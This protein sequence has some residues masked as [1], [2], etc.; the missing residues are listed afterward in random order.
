M[1]TRYKR[2]VRGG[3]TLV[4][5]IVAVV[6]FGMVAAALVVTSSTFWSQADSITSG[7]AR[8]RAMGARSI[9]AMQQEISLATLLARPLQGA[10]AGFLSGAQN[11]RP[12]DSGE[13]VDMTGGED[14]RWF[15]FCVVGAV[16]G[17]DCIAGCVPPSCQNPQPCLWYY[18]GVWPFPLSLFVGG[19]GTCGTIQGGVT[20][21]LLASQI[22]CPTGPAPTAT[23]CFTR[24]AGEGVPE[25]NAVRVSFNLNKQQTPTT[26]A[27]NF[28]V[29]TTFNMNFSPGF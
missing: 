1:M 22:N 7:D 8:L 18:S 19:P 4:E 24:V 16:G 12:D 26:P 11:V 15:H 17:G 2:R 29:D 6:I 9:R 14:R 5:M 3:F 13:I 21:L 10:S 23:N 28:N 20:P 27:A 25:L